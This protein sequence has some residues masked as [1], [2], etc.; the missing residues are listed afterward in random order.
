MEEEDYVK[1]KELANVPK[2]I[3]TEDM[4]ILLDLIKNQVCKITCKDGS[5]GTG[6]FCN[7]S[8]DWSNNIK[9]LMTNNHVLN[10]ND[11]Q[12]GQT[13]KFSLNNDFKDYK[14]LIDE[15]RKTYTNKAYDVTIIEIKK[16]DKI[17]QKSFF[18]LDKQIFKDNP[19]E[20]FRR[21]QIYVLHYPKGV[22]MEISPGLIK[23]INQDNKTIYHLCDT[24]DGSSGSPIINKANFQVIGIHKGAPRGAKNYNLG[25][26][27]KEP[28]EK[29]NEEIKIN[30]IDNKETKNYYIK[31]NENNINTDKNKENEKISKNNNEE[32]KINNNDEEI[33]EIIIQY[34]IDDIEYSK[35][36]KIFGDKFVKNN[37]NKC[38][39]IINVN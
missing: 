32:N 5:H 15:E 36:L 38:K 4:I 24:N 22:K 17:D 2:A 9:V 11:I 6:F 10:E 33:D 27:L 31:E 13:I 3:P 8:N 29:L 26:L 37:K 28:I 18:D 34:K 12:P 16:D 30:K 20:I 39:I 14:I 25:T 7:I 35:D 1:E 21:N 19:I 23:D